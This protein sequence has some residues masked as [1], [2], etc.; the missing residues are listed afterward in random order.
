MVLECNQKLDSALK[1]IIY[2]ETLF[3]APQLSETADEMEYFYQQIRRCL[4]IVENLLES[5]ALELEDSVCFLTGSQPT[6]ADIS[7]ICTLLRVNLLEDFDVTTT[8]P[9]INEW[10][11]SISL[12]FQE[13]FFDLSSGFGCLPR[14]HPLAFKHRYL[15]SRADSRFDARTL[16]D[17]VTVY[18]TIANPI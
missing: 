11:S 12:Y 5:M 17:P 15:E 3:A 4:S 18:R 16:W 6:I 10:A 9:H 13:F 14:N 1:S 8:H 7:V 2:H